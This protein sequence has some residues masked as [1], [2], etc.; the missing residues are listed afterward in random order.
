MDSRASTSAGVGAVPAYLAL[1]FNLVVPMLAV[2]APHATPTALRP[3]VAEAASDRVPESLTGESSADLRVAKV[4]DHEPI[5][6]GEVAS[7]HLYVWNAG[8]GTAVDVFVED[9]LPPGL[10]WSV[11]HQSDHDPVTCESSADSS[12]S[13][14]YS[15]T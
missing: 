6:A 4:A 3:Q 11:E 2:T 12:G 14:G 10:S 15:C 9:V 8:P 13:L 7:Y 1:L 5:D